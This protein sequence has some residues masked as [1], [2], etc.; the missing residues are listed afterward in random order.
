MVE[1]MRTHLDLLPLIAG[2]ILGLLTCPAT[3]KPVLLYSRYF[4]AEG[5]A[6]Y[7]PDKDYSEV[8]Q[9]L[10]ST[11][12]VRAEQAEPTSALLDSVDVVLISNP[13]H[14]AAADHPARRQSVPE[15]ASPLRCAAPLVPRSLACAAAT[16][17]GR[18]H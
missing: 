16:A 13:S 11:F 6:R 4:N 10:G 8:L 9:R 17:R 3:A 18:C 2:S 15:R 14:T 7:V 12:E 5:E 1:P